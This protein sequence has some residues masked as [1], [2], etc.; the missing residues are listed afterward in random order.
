M[1]AEP[2]EAVLGLYA[3]LGEPAGDAFQDGMRRW[4]AENAESREPS[5]RLDANTYGLDL[6][7]VRERFAPYVARARA[8]TA[9]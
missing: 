5:P 2:V 4:W 6:D 8:W 1:Q 9:P 7:R 3:W